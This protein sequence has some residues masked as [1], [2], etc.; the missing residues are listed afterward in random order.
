MAHRADRVRQS[1]IRSGC[2]AASASRSR[3]IN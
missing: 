2:L 3:N 1:G